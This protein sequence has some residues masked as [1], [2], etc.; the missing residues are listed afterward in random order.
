MDVY[1]ILQ[2]ANQKFYI[3]HVP[4][5]AGMSF[6]RKKYIQS[7]K[8]KTFDIQRNKLPPKKCSL[9]LETSSLID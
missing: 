2:T 8:N 7:S 3:P 9:L 4:M 1:F 6:V 5:M